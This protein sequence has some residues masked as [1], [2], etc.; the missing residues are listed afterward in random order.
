MRPAWS[1]RYSQLLAPEGNLVCGEFPSTKPETLG[2]PPWAL[3]AKVHMAHLRRPGENLE[4][5]YDKNAVKDAVATEE[6]WV[7]LEDKL[8]EL[9]KGNQNGL[10][11]VEHFRP[12]RTHDIGYSENGEVM[13]M[14]SIWKHPGAVR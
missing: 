9:E 6:R 1:L 11:R 10:V 13:D 2:G 3:S 8:K 5:A 14:I 4:Y 7:L 12:E